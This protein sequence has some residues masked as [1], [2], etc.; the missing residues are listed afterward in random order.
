MWRCRWTTS[1]PL[2]WRGGGEP[3]VVP[4]D[5]FPAD[6]MGLD[7]GPVTRGR[8]QQSIEEAR[9]IVWNGPMGVFEQEAYCQRLG[10]IVA[11]GGQIELVLIRTIARTTAEDWVSVLSQAEIDALAERVRRKTRLPVARFYG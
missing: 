8:Y 7:I 4:S 5:E 3:Q 11:C 2:S 6:L 9:T 1:L 10:E